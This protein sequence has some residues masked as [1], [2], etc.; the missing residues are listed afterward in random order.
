MIINNIIYVKISQC[1]QHPNISNLLNQRMKV[2]GEKKRK[3]QKS[4]LTQSY[5]KH[6]SPCS[7]LSTVADNLALC[8]SFILRRWFKRCSSPPFS[9]SWF[10]RRWM[11]SSALPCFSCTCGERDFWDDMRIGVE[12]DKWE[13]NTNNTLKNKQHHSYSVVVC[14][15][16]L[17][18]ICTF[19][20]IK[21]SSVFMHTCVCLLINKCIY[22]YLCEKIF[23]NTYF[24]VNECF[25]LPSHIFSNHLFVWTLVII[26]PF[27]SYHQYL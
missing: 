21:C 26:L 14:I 6:N 15:I 23:S 5:T 13:I 11:R 19:V 1:H 3:R 8:S 10:S 25:V 7:S 20:Y 4:N 27:Q 9:S 2:E 22:I 24:Y 12:K 16:Y 18:Y 17:L